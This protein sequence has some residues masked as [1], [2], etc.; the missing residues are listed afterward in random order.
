MVVKQIGSSF[1]QGMD[2]EAIEK[3]AVILIDL[4]SCPRE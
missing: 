3:Q 2:G 1:D 4:S